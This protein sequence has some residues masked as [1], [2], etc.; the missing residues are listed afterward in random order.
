VSGWVNPLDTYYPRLEAYRTTT[1]FTELV[2]AGQ[3]FPDAIEG[4]DPF[5]TTYDCVAANGVLP[6]A[7]SNTAEVTEAP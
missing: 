3:G 2:I 4:G 1:K 6:D 5:G 7:T